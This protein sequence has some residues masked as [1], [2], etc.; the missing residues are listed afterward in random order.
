MPAIA[1]IQKPSKNLGLIKAGSCSSKTKGFQHII[2]SS[3]RVPPHWLEALNF[4]PVPALSWLSRSNYR[5]GLYCLRRLFF[6]L[7]G[8]FGQTGIEIKSPLSRTPFDIAFGF[9]THKLSFVELHATE[10]RPGAGP[11]QL[12]SVTDC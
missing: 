7:E 12:K 2:L 3:I 1:D 10:S 9:I 11:E 4:G 5:G 6:G 8:F